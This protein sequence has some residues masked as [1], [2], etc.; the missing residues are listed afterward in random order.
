[1]FRWDNLVEQANRMMDQSLVL[2]SLLIDDAFDYLHHRNDL[3]K[4][5]KIYP[6]FPLW[7]S[8]Y[9]DVVYVFSYDGSFSDDQLIVILLC[10][11]KQLHYIGILKEMIISQ[12]IY[13]WFSKATN[14]WHI[15]M[16]HI[17]IKKNL[18]T[19]YKESVAL[20]FMKNFDENNYCDYTKSKRQLVIR[21][22]CLISQ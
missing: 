22:L 12:L 13:Q 16:S 19:S 15:Q 18:W 11:W 9:H 5:K 21:I 6:W 20:R 2:P 17:S 3:L 7:W 4:K 14:N 10:C 1:M 8:T